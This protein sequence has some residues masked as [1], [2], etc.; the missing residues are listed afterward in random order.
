MEAYGEHTE[1]AALEGKCLNLRFR[2]APGRPRFP[3]IRFPKVTGAWPGCSESACGHGRVHHN[4]GFED[5]DKLDSTGIISLY[6]CIGP[7]PI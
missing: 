5:K 4:K 6:R 2:I 7:L 3:V 1:S